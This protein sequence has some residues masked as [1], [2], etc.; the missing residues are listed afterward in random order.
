[1]TQHSNTNISYIFEGN[2]VDA[3]HMTNAPYKTTIESW[4]NKKLAKVIKTG[5]FIYHVPDM[6]PEKCWGYPRVEPGYDIVCKV[7]RVEKVTEVVTWTNE[8][9]TLEDLAR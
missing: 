3:K 7:E 2:P 9:I 1:M 6:L 5:K 4:E 8:E